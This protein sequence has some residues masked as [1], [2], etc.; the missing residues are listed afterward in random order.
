MNDKTAQ[1][2]GEV[3]RR[4]F[5]T[6]YMDDLAELFQGESKVIVYL[7]T[8]EGIVYP[9]DISRDLMIS[10]QRVTSV[11]S[12]MEKKGFVSLVRDPEDKRRVQVKLLPK[13]EKSIE[14]KRQRLE[15]YFT[16]FVDALGEENL[17]MLL[18]SSEK[19]VEALEHT[20]KDNS[21]KV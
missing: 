1:R 19:A 13:G 4:F 8:A 15:K 6:G 16:V 10:R 14:E 3:F 2:F 21:Q 12:T 5:E 9:S 18:D 20:M 11:L 7:S 17:H